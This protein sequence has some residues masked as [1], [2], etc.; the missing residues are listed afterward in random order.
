MTSFLDS[1]PGEGASTGDRARARA[2][3]RDFF[4]GMLAYLVVLLLVV[5]FGH[6]DGTSGWRWLWALAPVLPA[7]WIVLAVAR[8]LHR[9]DDYQRLLLLQQLAIGFAATMIAALTAG[10]LGIAGLPMR[11]AGWVVYG[12]GMLTWVVAAAVGRTRC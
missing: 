11:G 8:H 9:V 10:F 3:Y 2:Y 1:A 12:V 5:A 7:G 4:A 6:L